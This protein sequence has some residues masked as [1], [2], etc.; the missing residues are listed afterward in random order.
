MPAARYLH[1]ETPLLFV[2]IA[3]ITAILGWYVNRKLR[4]IDMLEALKSVE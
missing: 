3:L 1:R 2:L 4:R